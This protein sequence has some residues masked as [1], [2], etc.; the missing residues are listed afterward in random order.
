MGKALFMDSPFGGLYWKAASRAWQWS[1]RVYCPIQDSPR[2]FKHH[3]R[4][5]TAAALRPREALDWFSFHDE[6]AISGF[7]RA[8]PRLIFRALTSYMSVRWNLTHRMKV[9]QDTYRFIVNQGGFL[10]AAMQCREGMTLAQFDLGRG[11]KARIRMGSDAQFRKEGEISL[12]L[13]LDGVE[14]PVT[15]LAFSLVQDRG[16]IALIGGF[17][18]RKG[19]DE[20]TIK[21]ATKAM[22]GLR[23]KSLMI[24]LIQ[25]LAQTLGISELRGVGNRVQVFRARMNNPLVPARKIHFDFD[26]LWT[27]AEGELG[28]DGWFV[29]PSTTPRRGPDQIKP[30]KRSMYAKRYLL[31]DD[32]VGQIREQLNP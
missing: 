29:L 24:L 3:L 27:E 17:Q 25:E 9:I 19:G 5:A 26:A 10:E 20:E 4:W 7:S 2:S 13:E 11:Q 32:L 28:E 18:G 30:N 12:F 15:G 22:H 16:W 23:P 1:Q 31:L 21:L 14:G 6:P 8:N